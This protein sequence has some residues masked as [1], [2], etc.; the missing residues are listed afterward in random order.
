MKKRFTLMMMVLCFLMSIPLKMMAEKVTV[1]YINDKGWAKVCAYVYK[2]NDHIGAGWPGTECKT[3]ETTASG[4]NVA[5]WELDLGDVAAT[6]ALIIFNC[7]SNEDQTSASGFPLINN[8]YYN[9][10]G[11]ITDPSQGG[12]GTGGGTEGGGGTTTEKWNT[13]ETN[14]LTEKKTCIYSGFLSRW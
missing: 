8:Q 2:G 10:N 11:V 3:F 9:F 14:R 4:K 13:V 7:G 12:G 6:N 1:H 5:T